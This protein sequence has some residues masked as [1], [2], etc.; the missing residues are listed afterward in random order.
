MEKIPLTLFL[1]FDGVLNNDNFLRHQKNHVRPAE[2]KLFDPANIDA[3]NK[4]CG[5]LKIE[6]IVI[7]STWKKDRTLSDI[8]NLLSSEGFMFVDRVRDVTPILGVQYEARAD[9]IKEWISANK[10][11]GVLVLDDF[12][13]TTSIGERFFRVNSAEGLTDKLVAAIISKLS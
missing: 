7:S 10:P 11:Q 4:L 1:D 3:L 5:A 13:L 12:D 2:H 8:Q 9:E 6:K